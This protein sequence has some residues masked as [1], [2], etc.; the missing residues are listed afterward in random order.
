M[1]TEINKIIAELEDTISGDPWF[2]KSVYEML[3]EVDSKKANH[4][5]NENSHSL[6]D[7]LYHMITWTDFTL[8][9]IEKE[10]IK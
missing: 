2:G 10:K 4:K 8:K 9:R 7:L 3:G 1:K 6:N 5:P